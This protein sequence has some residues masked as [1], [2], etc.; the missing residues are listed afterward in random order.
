MYGKAG[1]GFI[2]INL[3]TPRSLVK[4]ATQRIIN[5]MKQ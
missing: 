4:E 3:A 2:R 5:A 1:D